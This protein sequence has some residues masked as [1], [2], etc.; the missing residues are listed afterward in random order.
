M[1]ALQREHPS[2]ADTENLQK[3]WTD[4]DSLIEARDV[5]NRQARELVDKYSL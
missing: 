3:Y 1:T 4:V 2:I 5:S